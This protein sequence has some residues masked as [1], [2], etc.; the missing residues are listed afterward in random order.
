MKKSVRTALSAIAL[1]F[2]NALFW[3]CNY[4]PRH[5]IE[6]DSLNFI[7]MLFNVLYFV[8]NGYILISIFKENRAH[9][10][11]LG[12]SSQK[13][14]Y[15]R[16]YVIRVCIL[17]GIQLVFDGLNVLC[18]EM[19]PLWSPILIDVLLIAQWTVIYLFLVRGNEKIT[20]KSGRLLMLICVL[21][22]L[23]GVSIVI[24]VKVISDY[25]LIDE[26]YLPS[27]PYFLDAVTNG[28]FINGLKLLIL[29]MGVALAFVIY[30]FSCIN[31]REEKE[32]ESQFLILRSAILLWG[33]LCICLLKAAISPDGSIQGFSLN[34]SSSISYT[35]EHTID[36]SESTF[37]VY[38][39]DGREKVACYRQSRGIL[40]CCDERVVQFDWLYIKSNFELDGNQITF[41]VKEQAFTVDGNSVYLIENSVIFF[42][43]DGVPT[44]VKLEQLAEFGEN[45]TVIG[46]CEQLIESGNIRVF[47]Y[48]KD[49]LLKYDNDFIKPYLE[50]Y[51]KGEFND[52]ELN[53]IAYFGYKIE[54][55]VSKISV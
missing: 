28:D 3:L 48:A 37:T 50:R 4:Y 46:V 47:E 16:T 53:Y 7:A 39:L 26:K 42:H 18:T 54:Y 51:A 38:R 6:W 52:N 36:L 5:I 30:H 20:W 8:L 45:T 21:A 31:E 23:L 35:E 43:Q 25:M 22:V 33:V 2:M 19:V 32:K 34:D 29:E 15:N 13:N 1:V 17:V 44:A 12:R 55:I 24:D 14:D 40:Y 11:E 49:Y 10:F 9:F 27:S 41:N